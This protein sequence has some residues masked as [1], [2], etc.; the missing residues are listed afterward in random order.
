[1]SVSPHIYVITAVNIDDR[2]SGTIATVALHKTA[3]IE[4]Q[5]YPIETNII[6][7][8]SYVD[9]IIDIT[10]TIDEAISLTENITKILRKGNFIMKGWNMSSDKYFETSL[11]V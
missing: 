3:E 8:S 11:E 2:P 1:M 6:K 5:N 4:E 9:D 7:E 10:G